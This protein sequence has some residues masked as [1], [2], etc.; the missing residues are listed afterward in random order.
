MS[1]RLIAGYH[2]KAMADTQP[3]PAVM[4]YSTEGYN[5]SGVSNVPKW[6]SERGTKQSRRDAVEG[7]ER[8]FGTPVKMLDIPGSHFD[9]FHPSNVSLCFP[10]LSPQVAHCTLCPQIAEVSDSIAQAC[11]YLEKPDL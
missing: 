1:P 4:L 2:P 10:L 5:P 8:L 7:W 6:I 9:A 11:G 3:I